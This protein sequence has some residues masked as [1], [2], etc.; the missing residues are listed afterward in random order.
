MFIFFQMLLYGLQ[1]AK[2]RAEIDDAGRFFESIYNFGKRS[3]TLWS[4]ELPDVFID[5]EIE[6]LWGDSMTCHV[7]RQTLAKPCGEYQFWTAG[8]I[9][10]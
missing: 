8:N 7:R 10:M 3:A 5:C 2:H 6:G 9:Y 4:P 1:H